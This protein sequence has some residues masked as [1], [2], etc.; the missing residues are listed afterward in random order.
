M[1]FGRFWMPSFVMSGFT[2]CYAIEHANEVMG[3]LNREVFK[4]PQEPRW[5]S[6][7]DNVDYCAQSTV[8]WFFNSFR[9]NS[10]ESSRACKRMSKIPHVPQ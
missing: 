6:G 10:Q 1:G 7:Q 2:C 5:R 8:L 9:D 3:V 4:L